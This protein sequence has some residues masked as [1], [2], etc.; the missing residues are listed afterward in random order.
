MTHSDLEELMGAYALDALD[1]AETA[2]VERHLETCPRCRAEVAAH[3]E[4]AAILGN[5]AGTLGEAGPVEAPAYLWGR[6]AASLEQE[7][8]VLAPVA[9]VIRPARWQRPSLLVSVAAV[10][11]GLLV[12]VGLLASKVSNLNSQV[13]H[14]QSASGVTGLVNSALLDP[15]HRTVTLS[16]ATSSARAEV[17][18]LPSGTAYFVARS[19]PRLDSS[20]TFQLW[21]VSSGRIVSLGVLGAHPTEVPI[22]LQAPMTRLMVT[23]EPAG[24]TPVPTTPLLMAASLPRLA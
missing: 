19:L 23:A 13:N 4:V 17:V 18:V 6:I 9:Q 3:R 16:A 12:V 14:I 15:A 2:E 1:P 11:A 20:Q 10:A 5:T 24:G 7:P 8:P 21:A 22:Q